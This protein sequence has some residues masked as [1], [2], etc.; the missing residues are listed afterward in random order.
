MEAT[1]EYIP[2]DRRHESLGEF[3]EI[4]TFRDIET[5]MDAATKN[6]GKDVMSVTLSDGKTRE[7]KLVRYVWRT[8][9]ETELLVFKGVRITRD[10]ANCKRNKD[11]FWDSMSPIC[12]ACRE[13]S[14][15]KNFM[16][17]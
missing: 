6:H 1:L 17:P 12:D 9:L 4:P 16:L 11:G 15:R 13:S 5:I 2:V 7:I 10:C 3:I 8:Y 14:E